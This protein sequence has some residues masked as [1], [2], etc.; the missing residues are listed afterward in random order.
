MYSNVWS[1]SKLST[2]EFNAPILPGTSKLRELKCLTA[3]K[4]LPYSLKLADILASIL[5]SKAAIRATFSIASFLA[6][7][8]LIVFAKSKAFLTSVLQ[9]TII[10]T[11]PKKSSAG[12][13]SPGFFLI[14]LSA[15]LMMPF[16]SAIFS[17]SAID[18]VPRLA[19]SNNFL[20]C[21]LIFSKR[22]LT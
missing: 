20:F 4:P 17:S 10:K 11:P 16:F 9:L 19:S 22:L 7:G 2:Q 5:T 12:K 6:A 3:A 13:I 21:I 14:H 15:F 18:N 1:S 8:S